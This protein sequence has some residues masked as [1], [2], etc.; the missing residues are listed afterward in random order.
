VR[1]LWLSS[2][3][4]VGVG[5]TATKTLQEAG[6]TDDRTAT[7]FNAVEVH[8]HRLRTDVRAEFGIPADAELV[9][10]VGRYRS[11]KNQALLIDALAL[12]AP[13]R[14]RLHAL[15]VGIGSLETEL[16]AQAERSGLA[17]RVQITGPRSDPL[18]CMSAADVF[19]LTSTTEGL[20]LVLIEAMT[21]GTA[22][23][24]TDVGGVRDVA[25][26]GE[27]ALLVPSGD[28]VQLASAIARLLDDPGLRAQL[29]E[30]ALRFITATCSLETMVDEYLHI[31]T[32]AV[33]R[34]RRRPSAFRAGA[35][36]SK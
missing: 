7:V 1:A 29:S 34:R 5:P 30:A 3:I 4:V 9:V 26:E 6:L 33:Q 24:T 20:P 12:L 11:E 25:R 28:T 8:P 22:V 14:P 36:P 31:Y 27:T 35:S 18:D 19:A 10:T 17:D 21:Q 15:I 13:S 16:R 32:E 23:V 2:D